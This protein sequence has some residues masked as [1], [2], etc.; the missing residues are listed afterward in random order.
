MRLQLAE[1]KVSELRR[2]AREAGVDESLVEEAEDGAAP[3]EQLVE[4]IVDASCGAPTATYYAPVA[5]DAPRALHPDSYAGGALLLT[6]SAFRS[7]NGFSNRFWG[8]GHED[9]SFSDA[10]KPKLWP[11]LSGELGLEQVEPTP[12]GVPPRSTR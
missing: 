2:A 5:D 12:P 4:L 9:V 6:P 1:L 7:V 11:Y 10:D 3:K 8:W